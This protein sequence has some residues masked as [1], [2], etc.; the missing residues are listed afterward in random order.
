[1]RRVVCSWIKHQSTGHSGTDAAQELLAH[2]EIFGALEAYEHTDALARLSLQA[3]AQPP[4]AG[5]TRRTR[6]ARERCVRLDHR[7]SVVTRAPRVSAQ[8]MAFST[9]PAKTH[10]LREM[11]KKFDTDDSGTI[12]MS[13]FKQALQTSHPEL[14]EE[15]CAASA[16]IWRSTHATARTA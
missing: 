14:S 5:R 16:P 2:D 6:R 12:S 9:P 4:S 15:R 8:V 3:R 11:F 1:V 13:E 7:R 10:E